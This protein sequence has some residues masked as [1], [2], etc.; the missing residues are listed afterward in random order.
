MSNLSKLWEP[1]KIGALIIAAVAAWREYEANQGEQ[2]LNRAVIYAAIY[3]D[4]YISDAHLQ[5]DPAVRHALQSIEESTRTDVPSKIH[6]LSATDHVP[7]ASSLP[8]SIDGQSDVV[9]SIESLH[10][11]KLA[12]RPVA[13]CALQNVCDVGILCKSFL[14]DIQVFAQQYRQIYQNL[15]PD[16]LEAELKFAIRFDELCRSDADS[17]L[18]TGEE[19]YLDTEEEK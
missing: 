2:R 4:R 17:Y 6:Y 8:V 7:S 9:E 5:T 13:S 12:F 18:G 14:S 11:L 15:P 3:Q 10:A 1:L 16:Y 19:S